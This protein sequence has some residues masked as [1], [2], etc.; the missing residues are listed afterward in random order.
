V[1]KPVVGPKIIKK[2]QFSDIAIKEFIYYLQSRVMGPG[3][4]AGRS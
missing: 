1:N 4:S 3:P 2:R